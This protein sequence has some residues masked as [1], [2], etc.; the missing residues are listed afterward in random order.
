MLARDGDYYGP[1]VNLASRAVGQARR[2]TVLASGELHDAL[3]GYEGF[4]WRRLRRRR[5]R[6]IGLVQL[7]QLS[8]A[9]PP[10]NED[11]DEGR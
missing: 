3:D 1:V 2:G 11:E 6:D 10:E 8:R 7:W 9:Q 5:L 4:E